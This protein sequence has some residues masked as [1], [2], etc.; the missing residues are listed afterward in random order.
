V[1]DGV[2]PGFGGVLQLL[3]NLGVLVAEVDGFAGVV[4]EVG[5]VDGVFGGRAFDAFA[6]EDEFPAAFADGGLLCSSQKTRSW[7]LGALLAAMGRMSLPSS[8]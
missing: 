6:V 7:G 4:V 2:A 3:E 8:S 5:E 1:V